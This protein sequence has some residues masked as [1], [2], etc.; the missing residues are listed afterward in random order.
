MAL[1]QKYSHN[2]HIALTA[3]EAIT[4]GQPVK[5]GAYVGV[6]QTSAEAGQRVTIWLNGSYMVPVTGAVAEGDQININDTGELVLAS[7]G[8]TPFG[9]ANLA[10]ADAAKGDVE[11]APFGMVPVAG[12]GA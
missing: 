5:I 1:N 11:V 8:G 3:P 9:I 6:A 2:D 7:A 12:A 4:S 10:K